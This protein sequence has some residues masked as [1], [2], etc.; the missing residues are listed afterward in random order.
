MQAIQNGRN[1][2]DNLAYYSQVNLMMIMK[3]YFQLPIL[4]GKLV[5][6]IF[7]FSLSLSIK[8][9]SVFGINFVLKNGCF[10]RAC[11]FW[12]FLEEGGLL[13]CSCK[14]RGYVLLEAGGN[15]WDALI[16]LGCCEH[17]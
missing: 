2:A 10:C 12:S 9:S 6:C 14:L 1:L 5:V 16:D 3:N 11:L 13:F 8:A 17:L 4:L 7:T 15:K